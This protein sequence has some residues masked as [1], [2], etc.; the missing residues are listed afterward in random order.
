MFRIIWIKQRQLD[1]KLE[2]SINLNQRQINKRISLKTGTKTT[3]IFI[4]DAK[5]FS[6]FL[7]KLQQ[8]TYANIFFVL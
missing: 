2:Y 4:S 5:L 1:L 6:D 7:G 3:Q 8:I